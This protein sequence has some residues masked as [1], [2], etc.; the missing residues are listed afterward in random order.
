VDPD[1]RIRITPDALRAIIAR[2][3]RDQPNETCGLLVGRGDHILE[4]VE[5]AN[6]SAEPTRRYEISPVDYF[7]QIKRCRRINE[8]SSETFAVLGA[9]HS[10]PESLPEPSP[11]DRAEAFEGFVYLIVGPAVGRGGMEARAYVLRD[12]N[13]EQVPLVSEGEGE[14]V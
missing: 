2:A 14:D 8:Q 13:L 12:G 7:A 3:R 11:T 9:Y 5:A 10:H 1:G 4:A 6:A